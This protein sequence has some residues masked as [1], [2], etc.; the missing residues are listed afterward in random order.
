MI[1]RFSVQTLVNCLLLTLALAL[2]ILTAIQYPLAT[3]FP[4]GAD[5]AVYIRWTRQLTSAFST[6]VSVILHSWYPGT[7][8]LFSF[9]HLFPFLEWPTRFVWWISLGQIFTGLSL[10][11]LLY[12]LNGVTSAAVGMAIWAL[13]PVVGTPFFEDG[14]AAQLWSLPPLL[15]FLERLSAR[16]PL[17]VIILLPI[18]VLCHPITGAI[19]FTALL[20]AI[21]LL[22]MIRRQLPPTDRTVVQTLLIISAITVAIAALV[23]YFKQEI[24]RLT[25]RPEDSSRLFNYLND[26][27]LPWTIAAIPGLLL[28]VSHNRRRPVIA[29]VGLGLAFISV[30]LAFND[31]LGIGLWP[32]RLAPYFLLIVTLGA[33]YGLP[34][35]LA[36]VFPRPVARLL[37][38]VALF[39]PLAVGV[40]EKNSHLYQLY[41]SPNLYVRLHPN[42]LEAITWINHNLPASA[43]I[44]S[45]ATTRHYEWIPALTNVSWQALSED[46]LRHVR[47]YRPDGENYIIYF[48]HA[49]G[50]PTEVLERSDQYQ[51]V[52]GNRGALIAKPLLQ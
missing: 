48:T 46:K 14:T 9:A 31:R 13:T 50:P 34:W 11:W 17:G 26:Q 18:I 22:W 44:Y 21:P 23:L 43:K 12:R 19:A 24:L 37:F 33:A 4:M 20:I 40:W 16:S 10:G 1:L 39:L 2:L 25:I 41:E 36:Q 35:A 3:T 5:A 29:I 30:I 6:T 49:E 52:F 32:N 42:E 8:A 7:Y 45:S 47:A 38:F 27:F 28:F 51:K 15:L